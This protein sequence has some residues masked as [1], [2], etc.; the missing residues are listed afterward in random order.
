MLRRREITR[1]ALRGMKET[2]RGGLKGVLENNKELV[3][4]RRRGKQRINCGNQELGEVDE[5]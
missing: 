3:G 2:H 1:R 5:D 4:M